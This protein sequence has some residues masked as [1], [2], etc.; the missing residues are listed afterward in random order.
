MVEKDGSLS[1]FEILR[2]IG[3]GTGEEAIRVLKL[4]QN[5][6]L[7]KT[8]MKPVRVKY[9]LPIQVEPSK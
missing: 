4:S 2:D 9:S 6:F 1:E 7:E 3:Y 5:G 8:T